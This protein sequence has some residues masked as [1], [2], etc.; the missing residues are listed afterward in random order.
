MSCTFNGFQFT[1]CTK[2]GSSS[3]L[4]SLELLLGQKR[5]ASKRSH[6]NKANT[7]KQA[8]R[9]TKQAVGEL[10]V[11]QARSTLSKLLVTSSKHALVF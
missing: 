4:F 2:A 1:T 7:T 8:D 5:E 6:K 10:Y 9:Q 11:A 3:D